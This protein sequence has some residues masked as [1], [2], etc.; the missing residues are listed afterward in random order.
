MS[1]TISVENS[2]DKE[3]FN[4]ISNC[5]ILCVGAGGIG[6]E[7][8]K[9][10]VLCGFRDIEVIDLDTIDVSN[11]NRQFLFRKKHVKTSKAKTAADA[12]MQFN[13]NA[14][15]ISH[16]GDVKDSK[17][18]INYIKKFKLVL[19]ALDNVGARR[20]MNRV[21]L[22]AGV[23]LLD[24]GTT[25]FLGQVMPIQK[26]ITSCYDCSP[27]TTQKVYPICTIRSTPDKPVHCVVWGKE[28][29]KLIFGNSSESMLFDD[30]TSDDVD[31][32][33]APYMKLIRINLEEKLN[34]INYFSKL[35]EAL[36]I[37]DIKIKIETDVYKSAKKVPLPLREET[38][39]KSISLINS[40]LSKTKDYCMI[41]NR[42]NDR[43]DYDRS[44]LNDED[45][46]SEMIYCII[47]ACQLKSIG[48]MEFDKDDDLAMRFVSAAANL[49]SRIFNIDPM[50]LHDTKGVAGNIIPAIA[51]TNAIIAGLQVMAG[52]KILKANNTNELDIKKSCPHTYCLR[53]PTRKGLYLQPTEPEGPNT[54][55]FVCS[56]HT[57]QVNVDIK[58][59]TVGKFL[60]LV[61]KKH[62]GFNEPTIAV[63]ANVIYE[64]GED[65]DE[66][67]K[68]NLEK[69]LNDYCDSE[70]SEW[71]IE[72]FSQDLDLTI[73]INHKDTPEKS[74]AA[75]DTDLDPQNTF[76]IIK[77]ATQANTTTDTAE[78]S[79][80]SGSKRPRE[81]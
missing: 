30:E 66:D 56:S 25:G 45:C 67:L 59:W 69:K 78:A 13:S 26:G 47:E 23:P 61:L 15:I 2:L 73:I 68:I 62:L 48:R 76:E 27:P 52:M 3:H 42:I 12:A 18:G 81:E 55:C 49:R 5:K 31:I 35:I 64:E 46:V 7:I 33:A 8:L 1:R 38:L 54:S 39:Q 21:C 43:M 10:L 14:K 58:T 24:S 70:C 77:D 72:D 20:H 6:C 75:Q 60:D 4:N 53:M 19:N 50:S 63:G 11:L 74:G 44:V 71:N 34:D 51:T 65:A 40:N 79:N 28:C 22:A 29:F 41:N 80:I 32:D 16:H 17:F 57:L 37:T 9:N 36:F